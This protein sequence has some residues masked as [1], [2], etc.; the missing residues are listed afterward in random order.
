MSEHLN[1]SLSLTNVKT[2]VINNAAIQTTSG[3]DHL[4]FEVIFLKKILYSG[5]NVRT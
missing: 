2:T 1:V 3:R 4:T 5:M